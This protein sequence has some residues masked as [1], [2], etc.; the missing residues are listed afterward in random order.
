MYIFLVANNIF[1][2]P[3]LGCYI[4]VL[5]SLIEISLI[6]INLIFKTKERQ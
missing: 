4:K 6:H 1:L 5:L 3:F 2:S